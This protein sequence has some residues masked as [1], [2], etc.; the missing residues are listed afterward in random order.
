MAKVSP[1]PRNAILKERERT[2]ALLLAQGK[3]N[4]AVAAKLGV[5]EKTIWNYR[6]KPAVQRV[7]R[8]TQEE[9]ADMSGSMA[10]TVIPEAIAMLQGILNDPDARDSDKI[11]AARTLMT[12]SAAFQERKMLERQITNLETQLFPLLGS[13]DK[14]EDFVD[15][16]VEADDA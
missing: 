9:F 15:I 4:R 10:V 12:G 2:A 14:E 3:T 1:L 6:Q 8:E 16:E 11:Q 7:I 5:T 13:S